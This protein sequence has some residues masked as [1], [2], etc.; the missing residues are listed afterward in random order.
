MDQ[1]PLAANREIAIGT[2]RAAGREVAAGGLPFVTTIVTAQGR[3]LQPVPNKVEAQ[4]DPTA[5]AEVTAIRDA[6]RNLGLDGV[7]GGTMY[8]SCSP[9]TLCYV[10]AFYAGIETIFYTV[11]RE[12]AGLYGCDLRGTYLEFPVDSEGWGPSAVFLD[13]EE[14]LDPFVQWTQS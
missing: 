1:L 9:C 8:T 5:H 7:R 13:I 10:S 12:E 3:V 4:N 2:V 11:T 14:R 6:C